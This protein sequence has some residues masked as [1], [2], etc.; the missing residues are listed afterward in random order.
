MAQRRDGHG[1]AHGGAERVARKVPREDGLLPAVSPKRREV[2]VP[3][4][5]EIK[6]CTDLVTI[7]TIEGGGG[8]GN[9]VTE[10]SVTKGR[11]EGVKE[12][13]FCFAGLRHEVQPVNLLKAAC[14]E[15]YCIRY[16]H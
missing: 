12:F 11:G 6:F 3:D 9:L 1:H 10:N 4:P 5:L 13:G 7:V 8:L 16:I 14:A 15:I 2:L